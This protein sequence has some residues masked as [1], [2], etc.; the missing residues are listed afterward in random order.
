MMRK[1]KAG[2]GVHHNACQETRVIP[3]TDKEAG[4]AEGR[5][6]G[7][8]VRVAW[9]HSTTPRPKRPPDGPRIP[10]KLAP[11]LGESSLVAF[12]VRVL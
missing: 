3:Q 9:G 10:P 6:A 2:R 11:P 12:A 5:R 4:K 1:R 8:Y 7:C